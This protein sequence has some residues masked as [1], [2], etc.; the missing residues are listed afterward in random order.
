MSASRFISILFLVFCVFSIAK[1]QQRILPAPME[2]NYGTGIYKTNKKITVYIDVSRSLKKNIQQ[3]LKQT[4]LASET[5]RNPKADIIFRE[6]KS[7]IFLT[8][9]EAYRLKISESGIVITAAS[10]PGFY[11]AL[12]TLLQ[13]Q[14]VSGNEKSYPEVEISD[15]PRF[16]YRGFMMDVSRHFFDTGFLKKQ[17]DVMAH[18]K[19]N[20]LHLHLTDAAG[21]RIEIKKYPQLTKLAA[22]RPE[23]DWKK[24]WFGNRDYVLQT[25]ENAYGG[26]YTQNEI[27]ELVQYASRRHIT[28]IPEIEMPGH[29]EEVMAA[30]PLLACEN[31]NFPNG[32]VCAGKESTYTFFEDILTE[33]TALFPSEYLH[34]GAD[35]AGKRAWKTC[36]HCIDRMKKEGL[37]DV[38][39][40]QAYFV[41]RISDFLKTKSRKLIGWDEISEN[42]IPENATVMVW[43]NEEKAHAALENGNL[44]IMSPGE[45]CYFDAYQDAPHLQPEAIGGYLPIEKVYSYNPLKLISPEQHHLVSGVQANLWT[46]YIL[47]AEHAETMIWPRLLALAEVVWT[48][49]EN[50][51]WPDFRVKALS[52]TEKLKKKGYHPFD[53]KNE[54]GNRPE[55]LEPV[56]HAA[57]G[58]K[59]IYNSPYSDSYA[60][61]G[62]FT[63]TDGLRGGWT[64]NDK[65]WQGFIGPDRL[66]V[67]VDIDSI[68]EVQKILCAFMQSAGA[69][70]YFPEFCE[71]SASTDGKS[72]TTV[73]SER[74]NINTDIPVKFQNVEWQGN[75][76]ARY[77]RIKARAGS[78]FG[79]WIFTDE[80]VINPE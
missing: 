20:R 54:T 16:K 60:A 78:K 73:H 22:W 18:Y 10:A 38:N 24:W 62:A 9:H 51:S 19:L 31:V 13:L 12:Q 46:E 80:I 64:Y 23:P 40:L 35:E 14:E 25:S 36:P 47:T 66:D 3:Y 49:P 26:F 63:L 33:V 29:S 8:N 21:W 79:G 72:F 75:T 11:Y 32:D 58:K 6:D 57:S 74:K 45:F 77:I 68:T 56:K 41:N 34:I 37:E 42:K 39:E 52:E 67:V 1:A 55:W 5:T 4:D 17:I 30:Y 71:F 15:C 44:V 69:E 53:L 70:V 43:R 2:I 28:I 59:V 76:K 65:R 27:R 7:D 61:A 50:K 48:L